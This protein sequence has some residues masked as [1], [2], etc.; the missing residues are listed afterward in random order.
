[1]IDLFNKVTINN[2]NDISNFL[3]KC[4]NKNFNYNLLPKKSEPSISNGIAFITFDFGIDGVSIE[5]AKY[6]EALEQIDNNNKPF[7]HFIA[8]DFNEK[9]KLPLKDNYK[10]FHIKGINGWGKWLDGKNFEKLFYK[11]MPEGNI[12]D[13]VAQDV[14]KDTKEFSVILY[15]YLSENN[16]NLLIPVNIMS[17]P[18]NLALSLAIIIVS[19]Y[20]DCFVLSSNHDFYW[21]G[22]IP[23]EDRRNAE[24]GPRDYFFKNHTNKTF[25]DL[26]T[27]IYPWNGK[28][29]LQVNIN[30]LQV[31]ELINN[32]KFQKDRVFELGTSISDK[33][34]DVFSFN[35]QK[36]TRLKMAYILSDGS[37]IIKPINIKNYIAQLAEWMKNQKP[38]VCAFSD[39]LTLDVTTNKTIYCLQPTRVVERKRIEMNF[40][41]LA[42]LMKHKDFFDKF[43]NDKEYQ[44]IVHITGPIPIE[45]QNDLKVVLDAYY[46]LCLSVPV[47]VANRIFISFSVGTENHPALLKNNLAPLC[48]EE[49]YRLATVILFPSETEGRGLPIIEASACGIPIICSRYYP[50]DVFAKVIG[51][52]LS[53]EN[54]IKY[55]LFPEKVY[56]ATFLQA[57]TDI[58]YRNKKNNNKEHNKQVVHNRYSTKMIENKFEFLLKKLGYI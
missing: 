3:E 1:M 47:Q 53:E 26:F 48:I 50:E 16:I 30:N 56:N 2:W 22:G 13:K 9:E 20:L 24:V 38:I 17:N 44:L 52:H 31:E 32:F 5:I 14:W 55:I 4:K 58:L 36:E 41:M 18:G 25:F 39:N 10:K 7:I 49:I 15:N 57:V 23:E 8:G 6:A 29:W 19:E 40:E 34:F 33:F 27:N 46:D 37:P 11:N 28:K 12:S 21:E 45:H 54:Q 42:A 51:E 43:E 35:D